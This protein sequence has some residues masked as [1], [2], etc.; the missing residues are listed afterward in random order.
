MK[1]FASQLVAVI[2]LAGFLWYRPYRR[3]FH[4][5]LQALCALV[6]V[7]SMGWAQAGGWEA[8]DGRARSAG[9]VAPVDD[10]VAA[11]DGWAL[12]ALHAIVLLPIVLLSLFTAVAGV[13]VWCHRQTPAH[14]MPAVLG[15]RSMRGGGGKSKAGADSDSD[16]SS[17]W[18]SWS[19][20]DR[21]KRDDDDEASVGTV[22]LRNAAPIP[23]SRRKKSLLSPSRLKK[24]LLSPSR[25]K[26]SF[27][28]SSKRKTEGRLPVEK[29]KHLQSMTRRKLQG[30]EE[31]GED[32]EEQP[33][34]RVHSITRRKP[35]NSDSDA[36]DASDEKEDGRVPPRR[37]D[38][39]RDFAGVADTV[40]R[41][42]HW[43]K[44]AQLM[45]ALHM[46]RQRASGPS[47]SLSHG[48]GYSMHASMMNLASA[49]TGF[50]KKRKKKK[51]K[52]RKLKQR[53]RPLKKTNVDGA[54]RHHHHHRHHHGQRV[55]K[56]MAQLTS[57]MDAVEAAVVEAAA[58]E[59]SQAA[60]DA[61]KERTQKRLQV[62]VD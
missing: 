25:R 45:H 43:G 39:L 13:Y 6:P 24:N 53:K 7:L 54:R 14:A 3:S 40:H 44:K 22:Q 23:G 17:S 32:G 61:Q 36:S 11:R 26:K 28:T 16:S 58:L 35:H 48:V 33:L 37:A 1:A 57:G 10:A 62:G 46:Q 38:T 41:V 27:L 2:F 19:N 8:A 31:D 60:I 21:K 29:L 18:S 15:G 55:T 56:E 47:G 50:A 49:P 20:E 34:R 5:G 42:H 30:E 12:V 52:K 9:A 4:N 51:G 59:A